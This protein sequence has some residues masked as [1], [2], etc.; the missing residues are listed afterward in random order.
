MRLVVLAAL[1]LAGSASSQA[2]RQFGET[3][4]TEHLAKLVGIRGLLP[5]DYD[6]DGDIDVFATVAGSGPWLLNNLGGTRLAHQVLGLRVSGYV[7]GG[8]NGDF[9]R[10]G[11]LDVVLLCVPPATS[12]GQDLHFENDGRGYFLD[13]TKSRFP[14]RNDSTLCGVAGDVDG[15]GDL[16][17]VFG[18]GDWSGR[19]GQQ[20]KLWLN[21]GKGR[22]VDRSSQLPRDSDIT[23]GIALGDINGDGRLDIVCAN[24]NAVRYSGAQN[25]VYLNQGNARFV[26][27]TARALPKRAGI[28][29]ALALADVNGDRQLDLVFAET[30]LGGAVDRLLLGNGRGRF[31]PSPTPLPGSPQFS[32]SVVIEDVDGDKRPDILIGASNEPLRLLRNLG[33]AKFQDVSATWFELSHTETNGQLFVDLDRDGRREL[34]VA[35]GNSLRLYVRGSG[36]YVDASEWSDLAGITMANRTGPSRCAVG[37]IDGD[38]WPDILALGRKSAVLINDGSGKFR[39]ETAARL[40]PPLW[41]MDV[42]AADFDQDGDDDFVVSRQAATDL[43]LENRSGKLV[44]VPFGNA[45]HPSRGIA[46]GDADG[47]GDLDIV[48]CTRAGQNRLWINRGKLLFVDESWRLPSD[49]DHSAA[50]SF[51]DIDQDRDLDLVIANGESGF[52]ATTA[53]Q[54]RVYLNDGRGRFADATTRWLPPTQGA[55]DRTCP[56]GH[57]PR[58]RC[59]HRLWEQRTRLPRAVLR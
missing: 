44:A 50:A 40:V 20:N 30:G 43:L 22:F 31:N 27:V 12:N 55:H 54:N 52:S 37:R 56:G 29:L 18:C 46:I 26:D 24:G 19:F 23:H 28:T 39:D 1:I 9:D 42:K 11:D 10:D 25:R 5:G 6:R 59:G 41:A 51:V 35:D 58:R 8:V 47:D 21:D 7:T 17:L 4:K 13:T 36:H 32:T 34:L 48:I 53:E 2:V 16:D 33:S 49:S 14:A 3:R 15:D 38:Q 45:K 57:R